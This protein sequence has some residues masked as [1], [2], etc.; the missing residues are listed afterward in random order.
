MQLN[1]PKDMT[2]PG[3]N[4]GYNRF[5]FR[6]ILVENKKEKCMWGFGTRHGEGSA[7]KARLISFSFPGREHLDENHLSFLIFSSP[8][9]FD[10]PNTHRSLRHLRTIL[11]CFENGDQGEW[12]GMGLGYYL[13]KLKAFIV[14]YC[15]IRSLLRTSFRRDGAMRRS[16]SLSIYLSFCLALEP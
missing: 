12:Y 2:Q 14:I 5:D 15:F 6:P 16:H 9:R 11:F 3:K 8:F 7:A 1:H 13:P 4:L 10:L